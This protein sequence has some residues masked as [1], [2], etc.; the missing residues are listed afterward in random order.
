MSLATRVATWWKAVTRQE[1][2]ND[3]IEDELSF[4]I[5]AYANDLIRSGLP[6]EE[7]LQRARAELGG[8]AA[9]RENCRQAWGTRAWD[10][11]RSDLRYATRMLAKSPGFTAIAIASLALGIGANTTIFTITKQILL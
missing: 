1:Q 6:R 5:E 11:L 2:L 7:A 10:E 4:H 8:L 9:Q 3:E